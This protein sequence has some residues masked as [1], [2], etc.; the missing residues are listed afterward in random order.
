MCGVGW[1][2][3]EAHR[4]LHRFLWRL[5][6]ASWGEAQG[7]DVVP[8]PGTKRRLLSALDIESLEAAT[9][10]GAWAGN[11]GA[12]PSTTVMFV[13]AAVNPSPRRP[14]NRGR[15]SVPL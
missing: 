10:F 9:R 6:G 1:S 5:L 4:E 15:P 3:P 11:R 14:D 2:G 13:L 12:E 7:G 8:I